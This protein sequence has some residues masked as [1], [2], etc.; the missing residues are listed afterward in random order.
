LAGVPD[1]SATIA[2]IARETFDLPHLHAHQMEAIN[3]LL[4]GHDVLAVLPTG[5]GKSAIYEIAALLLNGP[6][7]I[8]SPLIALQRDQIHSIGESAA[9]AA[10]AVNSAVSAAQCRRAWEAIGS[11]AAKYLY[12]APEQL[13]NDEV[14][15]NLND[16]GVALIVVDEAH[17]VSAW[18]HDFRPDY[19]RLGAVI[20]RLGAP[21]IALTATASAPVRTDIVERL[22]LR[23]HREVI[24]SF[25][26]PELWLEV[27]R[28]IDDAGKRAGVL[29]RVRAAAGAASS[30]G[31]L[32]T[33]SRKDAE[34]FAAELQ[35]SGLRAAYY[36]A[37]M[38]STERERIHEQFLEDALDVVVATSAF[39]MGIDKPDVRFIVHASVPE[40][41]DTYYQQIGRAGRDGE[42]AR[43]MLFYRPEDLHLQRFLTSRQPPQDA[44][45]HVVRTLTET[46]GSTSVRALQSGDIPRARITR[47]VNLLEHA[48]AVG[49]TK[50]GYLEYVN[51][52]LD[53]QCAVDQA[54]EASRAHQELI[55]S[56]IE[57][58][59]GYA[60]T[61]GCRRQFLLG[62]FGEQFSQPCGHCDNCAAGT[63]QDNGG[64]D[65]AYPRNSTVRHV[66]FGHGV[67][68]SA[69]EDRLT[70][71][72]EEAGYKVLSREAVES[73]QLLVMEQADV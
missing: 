68:M 4:A 34:S 16:M 54:I 13:A 49:T 19:L 15:G 1:D 33:A 23:D 28:E 35:N 43:I 31:L 73:D 9:P 62:Y 63:A 21:I 14:I 36:H 50:R 10:V 59:R 58:M 57:M 47:A 66:E 65:D 67:V 51:P 46:T 3:Q 55:R 40:S 5:A 52:G 24:G 6:A 41:L 45:H 37:G 44:L 20:G 8:V 61:T 42:Q 29:E 17:C 12:L 60:E 69:S 39:G 64:E 70:V 71:L 27:G 53:P 56:R 26:R 72:F 11:G 2:R 7:V 32:Y 22:R 48:G 30:C 25:D 38:K 18:G